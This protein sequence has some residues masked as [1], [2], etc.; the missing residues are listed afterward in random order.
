MR[1]PDGIA[2]QP[3]ALAYSAKALTEVLPH[4][5]QPAV[6][7]VTVLVGIGASEHA[8]RSAAPVWREQGLRAYVVP[9]AELQDGTGAADFYVA[10][11]ESGR[12]TETVA[13]LTHLRDAPSVGITNSP[14]SPL[15]AIVRHVLP[16]ESGPDS[17]VYTTGYTAT[18]QALGM[19][20]DA[21]SGQSREWGRLPE[22]A[23]T[24]LETAEPVVAAICATFE[25]ARV[26]DVIGSGSAS[27]SAG[28]GALLLRESA[29]V[30]TAAHETYNY[31]HGPM[32]P[33]DSQTA[34]LVVGNGREV[35]IAR[36]TSELGCPT[37]LLTTRADVPSAGNLTVL[38]LP[39]AS[40]PLGLAVLQ[41]LPIQLL[42]WAIAARRGFAVDGFRHHQDDTKLS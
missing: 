29:R 10:L 36:D 16:L 38:T 33:L 24:V 1:F 14:D 7:D 23:A 18:L 28:E 34:C 42:G 8:A 11:S 20:G 12:S 25:S 5:P 26:I 15:A 30:L 41:M 9:A 37:L 21:W 31:L 17:A 2:A 39:P 27:G 40:S 32:E 3:Q 4:L 22:Q 13:A 19:L 35:R 6:A